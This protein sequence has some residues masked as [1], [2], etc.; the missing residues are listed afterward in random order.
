MAAADRTHYEV[1][2]VS[3]RASVAQIRAA[4]RQLAQ[5]LHPDRQ[6]GASTAELALAERRMRE[7]NAAWTVLSD[8]ARRRQYDASLR[9]PTTSRT[10]G[11]PPAG[12]T[13]AGSTPR[14]DPEFDDPDEYWAR[15]RAAEIDPD[16][17]EL[18]PAQL[19]LLRRGP[20]VAALVVAVSLFVVTAVAGRGVGTGA[21]PPSTAVPLDANGGCVAI[22]NNGQAYRVSCAGPNAGRIDRVVP[23]AQSCPEGTERIAMSNEM[24]CVDGTR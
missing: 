10:T 15:R 9:A 5:L 3:R 8:P 17:P 23:L 14:S 11:S 21:P 19:W 1:L 20:I 24:A 13:A 2:G 16:E 6:A 4:H 18:H 12:A 7:V 22:L